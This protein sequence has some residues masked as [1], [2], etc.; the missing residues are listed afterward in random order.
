MDVFTIAETTNDITTFEQLNIT[1]D[2]S[3]LG[4]YPPIDIFLVPNAEHHLDRDLENKELIE[5]IQ[6]TDQ[7]ASYMT[8]HCDGAFVLPKLVF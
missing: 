5:F 6:K 1:P 2:F 4:D 8:S 3:Y 7:T